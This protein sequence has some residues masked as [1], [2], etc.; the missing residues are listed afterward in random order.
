MPIK[1]TISGRDVFRDLGF[2]TIEAENLKA[3]SDLMIRLT[4]L[5]ETRGLTQQEAARLMNV[6]QP[7]IRDLTRG[8]ID[9]FSIDSLVAMLGHMDIDVRFVLKPRSKVA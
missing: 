6:P 2:E 4:T 1:K 3:R 7:R 5:I 9:R 8:K